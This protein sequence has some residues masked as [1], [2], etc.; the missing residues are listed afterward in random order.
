MSDVIFAHAAL[1][2]NDPIAVEKFYS[3]YFGFRR[4]RVIQIDDNNQV[5]FVKND[6]NFYLEIFK[7]DSVRNS[8]KVTE[9]D[10]PHFDAIRHLAFKVESVDAK[11]KEMGNDAVISLGPFKF[12]EVIDGWKTVW[13]RD[14]EGNIVEI[15]QGYTDQENPPQL[16]S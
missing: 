13:V 5:V 11:L 4:A 3:N 8:P 6:Q 9:G 16:A 10:G 15:S 2:C 14:P 12:Y 7:A 1:S